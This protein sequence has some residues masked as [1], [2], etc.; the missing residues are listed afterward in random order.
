MT[1]EPSKEFMSTNR[2]RVGVTDSKKEK[3]ERVSDVRSVQKEIV[4]TT[5]R[6]TERERGWRGE[7]REHATVKCISGN[8]HPVRWN[9][10]RWEN[11]VLGQSQSESLGWLLLTRAEHS[12]GRKRVQTW[13]SAILPLNFVK[14][15][16]VLPSWY[17]RCSSKQQCYWVFNVLPERLSTSVTFCR[18]KAP[19]TAPR[20]KPS[21]SCLY[22]TTPLPLVWPVR[23]KSCIET[24]RFDVLP[25]PQ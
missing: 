24:Y 15:H 25:T 2:Q 18:V 19:H 16:S 23:Q 13:V 7:K 22:P 9:W 8:M 5:A 20:L 12:W 4:E 17:E 10:T 21:A 1:R 14:T 6:S 3:A 11:I